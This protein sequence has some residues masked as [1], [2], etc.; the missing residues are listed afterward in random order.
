MLPHDR[1]A[2]KVVL[3]LPEVSLM[4]VQPGWR[5]DASAESRDEKR[6][7]CN[8]RPGL[9]VFV[10]HLTRGPSMNEEQRKREL[11]AFLMS[12]R[13]RLTPADV[14]LGATARRCTPGL[15]RDD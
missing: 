15:R 2:R 9:L 10:A 1:N 5:D 12:R 3:P 4:Y 13:A 8:Q 6:N 11:R 14:G 7:A